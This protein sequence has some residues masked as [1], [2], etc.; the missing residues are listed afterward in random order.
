MEQWES[1][2]QFWA[3]GGAAPY[4]WGSYAVTALLIALELVFVFRCRT[5]TMRR[6]QAWRR[7][8]GAGAEQGTQR[9]RS[10]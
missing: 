2:S 3:M 7:A 9:P 1:W 8:M 5:Q 6:L 4:V 10:R